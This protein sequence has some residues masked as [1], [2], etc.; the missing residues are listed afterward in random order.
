MKKLA[1]VQFRVAKQSSK[2]STRA[3]LGDEYK[4][5]PPA[6]RVGALA[7]PLDGSQSLL[8]TS[9]L[10]HPVRVEFILSLTVIACQSYWCSLQNQAS[11]GP[12]TLLR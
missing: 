6:K 2:E 5:W 8:L 12:K 4:V 11:V 1:C 7:G 3:S 9:E 10:D